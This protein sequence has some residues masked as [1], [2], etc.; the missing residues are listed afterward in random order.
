V[1]AQA[2]ISI[3]D[4]RLESADGGMRAGM[5]QTLITDQAPVVCVKGVAKGDAGSAAKV[6]VISQGKIIATHEVTGPFEIRHDTGRIPQRKTYYRI[7]VRHKDQLV[8]T[9]PF[10]VQRPDWPENSVVI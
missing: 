3:E 10:F 7:E 5:G 2:S 4:C 8:I 9:N 6:D 1:S